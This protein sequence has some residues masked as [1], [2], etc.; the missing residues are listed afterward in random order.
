MPHTESTV[1]P[2]P[3]TF[4]PAL[5]P[6]TCAGRPNSGKR[7]RNS[8]VQ[9]RRRQYSSTRRLRRRRPVPDCPHETDTMGVQKKTR[10]FGEVKRVIGKNDARRKE[11][12]KKAEEA[13]QKAKRERGGPDGETIVRE[14]PQVP[15]Q[16]FFES[17]SSL[18][19]PYGVLVDTSFFS[20]T[21]QMKLPVI[22][23][24]MDCLYATCHPIVTDCVMAELEKLG[25]KFRLAL[26]VARDPRFERHKC[27]HKGVYADD[28]LVSKVSKDRVYLVATNDKGL[29]SRLRRIPG[30]P[31]M[32]CGRG[33]YTI[34][35][36]PDAP[37]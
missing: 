28:C 2:T 22:E 1:H 11:N 24:M 8:L 4:F 29:V 16:M 15:S 26:R 19:P 37:I 10:K 23:T 21:V 27:T 17:N 33:K 25:P 31:I 20:R 35:R 14:I 12:L 30:V 34:E 5:G 6:A 13:E 9:P 3:K 36:L 18:V 7:Q 32:K